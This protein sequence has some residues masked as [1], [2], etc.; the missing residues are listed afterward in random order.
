MLI[1]WDP[2]WG[3]C[4]YLILID[5][6]SKWIEVHISIYSTTLSI[7]IEELRSTFA[8]FGIPEI[9]VTDNGSNFTSSEFKEF[10]KSN[11]IHHIKTVL[12]HPALNGLAE[13]AIQTFKS[14]IK[15]LTSGTLEAQLQ[16]ARFLFNY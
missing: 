12:Y 8:I 13:W 11:G 9:L 6:H 2:S 5:E 3:K 4:M 16:V 1:L 7:T 14:G 15:K 10:L